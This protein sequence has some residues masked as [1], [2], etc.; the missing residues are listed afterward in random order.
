[1]IIGVCIN[2]IIHNH[3]VRETFHPEQR[4]IINI[5][6]D[7][8]IYQLILPAVKLKAAPG[9]KNTQTFEPDHL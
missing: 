2:V 8:W 6:L 7:L 1:M 4:S 3:C 9:H 5:D